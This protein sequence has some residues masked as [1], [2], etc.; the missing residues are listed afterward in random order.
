MYEH[1]KL[2]F[3]VSDK[4]SFVPLVIPDW[5]RQQYAEMDANE[6]I[7]DTIE[8]NEDWLDEMYDVKVDGMLS[9]APQ[10]VDPPIELRNLNKGLQDVR[11]K[12]KLTVKLAYFTP[13]MSTP[14]HIAAP[15]V[16]HPA[17]YEVICVVPDTI[18]APYSPVPVWSN[19]NVPPFSVVQLPLQEAVVVSV[20]YLPPR[21]NF[22]LVSPIFGE[23]RCMLTIDELTASLIFPNKRSISWKNNFPLDLIGTRIDCELNEISHVL[24]LSD[25]LWLRKKSV[26]SETFEKR[27]EL[28]T[29]IFSA[30]GIFGLKNGFTSRLGTYVSE[31]S[32]LDV[33]AAFSGNDNFEG[34]RC[35]DVASGYVSFMM[36]PMNFIVPVPGRMVL[37]LMVGARV[38]DHSKL[39]AI[40]NQL[41]P[42]KYI[43]VNAI[44]PLSELLQSMTIYAPLGLKPGCVYRFLFNLA[45]RNLTVDRET[46]DMV[47]TMIASIYKRVSAVQQGEWVLPSLQCKLLSGSV[48][49]AGGV[50][51]KP[52][53][54]RE[55][56]EATVDV[57]YAKKKPLKKHTIHVVPGNTLIKKVGTNML[58]K[59]LDEK[60][61]AEIA[62]RKK[63]KGA[64]TPVNKAKISIGPLEKEG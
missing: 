10:I 58:K 25:L 37:K 52:V 61:F 31:C 56:L 24:I 28:L 5:E 47:P 1:T 62:K 63:S 33:I 32:A 46:K 22:A 34:L 19:E 64:F 8:C 50:N 13:V 29:G 51:L 55:P 11:G 9:A 40:A 30:V 57:R 21:F 18:E 60:A 35:M 7:Y 14:Y 38:G 48:S 3:T 15:V 49:V 27:Q 2:P 20:D 39:Y 44:T 16:V 12:D 4:R 26:C 41:S 45:S 17:L 23:Q 42:L 59:K 53:W 6:F 36:N 43:D 54:T